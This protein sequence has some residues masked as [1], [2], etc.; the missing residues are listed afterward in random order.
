MFKKK[1][2]KKNVQ[3]VKRKYIMTNID[4]QETDYSV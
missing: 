4:T 3:I 1:K 2:K